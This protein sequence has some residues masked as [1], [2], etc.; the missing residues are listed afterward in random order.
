MPTN[1][2]S[3]VY[4]L[5][6]QVPSGKIT[7]YREIAHALNTHAYQAIGQALRKNP[8]APQVPC[9]RVIKSN[10]QLGGFSGQTKG[11][12]IKQKELLLKKE[13]VLFRNGQI[14]N[15]KKHLFYL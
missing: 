10:G 7:T 11:E 4:D 6:S 15:L 5:T 14:I 9:H 3:K 2:E 1:F 12:K 13:G 8:F